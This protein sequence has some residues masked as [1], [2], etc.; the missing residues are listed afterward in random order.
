MHNSSPRQLFVSGALQLY[1]SALAALDVDD[2]YGIDE[3]EE[4]PMPEEPK[5]VA[6]PV[7]HTLTSRAP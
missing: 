5:R 1:H 7:N 6:I 2:S 3:E 4:S